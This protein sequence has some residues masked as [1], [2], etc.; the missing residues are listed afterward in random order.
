MAV[1]LNQI[2]VQQRLVVAQRKMFDFKKFDGHSLVNASAEDKCPPLRP[3]AFK[4]RQNSPEGAR[5][6]VCTYVH[7]CGRVCMCVVLVS[8]FPNVPLITVSACC[9]ASFA[10]TQIHENIFNAEPVEPRP[11]SGLPGFITTLFNSTSLLNS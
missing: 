11:T 4:N 5:M 6:P 9:A 1:V 3:L 8:C 7:A 2:S 10:D